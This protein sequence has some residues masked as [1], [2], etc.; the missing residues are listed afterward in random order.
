MTQTTPFEDGYKHGLTGEDPRD[1]PY[2]DWKESAEWIR[3]HN[4]AIEIWR[5]NNDKHI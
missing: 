3:G 4:V 5:M 2:E 1:N